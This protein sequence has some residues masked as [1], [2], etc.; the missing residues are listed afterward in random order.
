MHEQTNQ[1]DRQAAGNAAMANQP[2]DIV[3]ALDVGTTKVTAVAGRMNEYGKIDIIA[4]ENLYN[5]GVVQGE[6][7]NILKTSERIKLTIENLEMHLES[8]VK[9]VVVGLSGEHI[10][11]VRT[12]EYIVRDNPDDMIDYN[13][14]EQL[15]ELPQKSVTLNPDEEILQI[16]PQSFKVDNFHLRAEDSPVGMIGKRLEAQFLVVIVNK[17]KTYKL[18]RSIKEAGLEVNE[19]YLQS[20]AS[21]E[22]VLS[23]AQK[24]AGVVLVDIGGGTSDVL[25]YHQG[26]IRHTAVIPY[27]GDFITQEIGN[28]LR[29][30]PAAAEKLKIK[31]GSAIAEGIPENVVIEINLEWAKRV[32]RIKAKTLARI[33]QVKMEYIGMQIQKVIDD[34]KNEMPGVDLLAGLV[35]TGGGAELKNTRQLLGTLLGM[36]VQIGIPAEHISSNNAPG[37]QLLKPKFS[38][39]AGLMK[40][41]FDH[42]KEVSKQEN[43]VDESDPGNSVE[44]FSESGEE[45][46]ESG[47]ESDQDKKDES[48]GKNNF[49]PDIN[50]KKPKGL[51]SIIEKFLDKF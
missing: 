22:S 14:I 11:T 38:T 30:L 21:A 19:I 5:V 12:N 1:P 34:F 24:Q 18:L 42:I 23:E 8:K 51:F 20:V 45:D 50:S 2:D 31:E 49:P 25:I 15:F 29:L 4:E 36:D 35:V 6:I 39:V 47:K 28:A 3:V 33:I 27:G 16:I 43:F 13:D 37:K 17:R 41:Y 48:S 9:G 10:R 26:V 44:G 40:I 46:E 32:Q 7:F